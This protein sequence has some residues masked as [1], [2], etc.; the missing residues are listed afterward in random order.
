MDFYFINKKKGV[1]VS[2][3]EMKN[4]VQKYKE[5]VKNKFDKKT[6]KAEVDKFRKTFKN[7]KEDWKDFLSNNIDEI[8][9]LAVIDKLSTKKLVLTT[10]Y[11]LKWR[12][13]F[14]EVCY[15]WM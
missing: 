6:I 7:V 3:K 9:I 12:K 14:G 10:F 1:S 2:S 4:V 11:K 15:F 5:E 8:A 13:R